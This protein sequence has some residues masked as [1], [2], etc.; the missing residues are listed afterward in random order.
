M[1]SA[2]VLDASALLALVLS[3]PGQSVVREL[4]EDGLISAVNFSETLA[5]LEE[6]GVDESVAVDMLNLLDLTIVPFD[7]AQAVATARLRKQTRS[8][9]LS[10]ADRACLALAAVHQSRVLTADREWQ[11]LDLDVEIILIRDDR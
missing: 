4:G 9:G 1:N 6:R 3:E 10:F 11:A 7:R 8:R 5:K 2:C